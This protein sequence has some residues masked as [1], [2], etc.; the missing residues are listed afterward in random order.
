MYLTKIQSVYSQIRNNFQEQQLK[1]LPILTGE[2]SFVLIYAYTIDSEK[3]QEL[4][5]SLLTKNLFAIFVSTKLP[6]YTIKNKNLIHVLVSPRYMGM[7]TFTRESFNKISMV[8][9]LDLPGNVEA[10]RVSMHFN[11]PLVLID[12]ISAKRKLIKIKN[13]E[14]NFNIL[15]DTNYQASRRGLGDIFIS[16]AII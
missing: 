5:S 14:S 13:L 11:I 7:T 12:R 1:K 2:Y 16:T 9:G 6:K 3:Y 4:I 15:F 8:M 10:A